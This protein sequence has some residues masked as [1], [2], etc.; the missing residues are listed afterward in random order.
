MEPLLA[1]I[2]AALVTAMT[3]DAWQK[4]RDAAVELWRRTDPDRAEAVQD[5]LAK[6]RERALDAFRAL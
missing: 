1:T 3:T 6:L 2:G 5:E 4:A